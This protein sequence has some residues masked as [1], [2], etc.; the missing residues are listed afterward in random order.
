MAIETGPASEESSDP[1]HLEPRA[2]QPRKSDVETR[3]PERNAEPY[4]IERQ[5]ILVRRLRWQQVYDAAGHEPAEGESRAAYTSALE[6]AGSVS[7]YERPTEDAAGTGE[8]ATWSER[9]VGW[10]HFMIGGK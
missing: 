10:L 6:S 7:H 4:L 9:L 8:A 5:A 2:K 1:L 3:A